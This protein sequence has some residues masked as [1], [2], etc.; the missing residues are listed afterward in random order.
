MGNTTAKEGCFIIDFAGSGLYYRCSATS[1]TSINVGTQANTWY[2]IEF[3]DKVIVDGIVK[4]A[5]ANYDFSSNT[6]TFLIG[7]ARSYGY[8]KFKEIKMYDGDELVRHLIPVYRDRDNKIGMLDIVSKKFYSS[9]TNQ[10]FYYFQE[11]NKNLPNVDSELNYIETNGGQYLNT[12][13]IFKSKPK[14]TA[15]IMFTSAIQVDIMGNYTAKNGCFIINIENLN[16]YYRYSKSSYTL[17][18]T[19]L[20]VYKWYNFEFSDKILIDGIEKGS[21]DTYDFSSNTQVFF[22]GKGRNKYSYAKF[23]EIK[24][25]D[26]DELVRDLVPY[27]KKDIN[28]VGM[29]DKV[30]DVFYENQ[31]TGEFLWG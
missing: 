29:L 1:S 2:N 5:V 18:N 17:F 4:G 31:G 21:I 25:Y 10:E 3:S 24:M 23:K 28:K 26:G 30:N 14:I 27:Y 11:E 19:N 6:Q 22:I 16:I 15:D 12:G 9:E 8:A 13:Y 7:K 20:K